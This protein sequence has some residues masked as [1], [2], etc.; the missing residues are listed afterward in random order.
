LKTGKRV[1]AESPSEDAVPYLL[2]QVAERLSRSL[3]EALK[4]F[5]QPANVYRVLIALE[6]RGS[7]LIGELAEATLIDPSTLSRTVDRMEEEGLVKHGPDRADARAIV[8]EITEKGRR[9]F[10]DIMPVASAQYEWTI[11][12][13]SAKQLTQLQ[14]TL[15]H[16]LAN[17][18]VSPVK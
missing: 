16:M 7:S 1:S 14:D 17:L 6:R 11:R 3:S 15:K 18:K 10:Y 8:V 12:G 9:F 4:P 13:L 2:R 5:G